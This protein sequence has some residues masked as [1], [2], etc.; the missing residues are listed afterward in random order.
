MS[1]NDTHNTRVRLS[2]A[3]DRKG[4]K[5]EKQL[6]REHLCLP[7]RQEEVSSTLVFGGAGAVDHELHLN[8]DLLGIILAL[9]T[10]RKK[11]KKQ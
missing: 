10:L 8:F 7:I 2:K 4:K 3:S 5:L 9:D 1:R 11:N 6:L